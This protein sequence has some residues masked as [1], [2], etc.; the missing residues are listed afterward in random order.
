VP[1]NVNVERIV[2]GSHWVEGLV[3]N[4]RE[5]HLLFSDIW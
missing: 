4:R 2:S 5:K 1:L 3:W